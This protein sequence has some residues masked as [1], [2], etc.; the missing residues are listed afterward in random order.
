MLQAAWQ[1]T[2]MTM[3]P[4]GVASPYRPR[5]MSKYTSGL[6]CQKQQLYGSDHELLP[7]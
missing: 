4:S 6:L 3:V 2:S 7:G 5:A 1:Q